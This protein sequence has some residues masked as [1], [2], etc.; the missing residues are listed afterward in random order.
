MVRK[1]Q[2]GSYKSSPSRISRCHGGGFCSIECC[3]RF[4]RPMGLADAENGYSF[5]T[6][7]GVCFTLIVFVMAVLYA[8]EKL[9]MQKLLQSYYETHI[10]DEEGSFGRKNGLNMAFALTSYT[11]DMS[12]RVTSP[13]TVTLT[14]QLRAWGTP[15]NSLITVYKN[16]DLRTHPCTEQELGFKG[17]LPEETKYSISPVVAD[18]EFDAK[19]MIGNWHCIDEEQDEEIDLFG[20]IEAGTAQ[21]LRI[22]LMKCDLTKT[23]CDKDFNYEEFFADKWIAILSNEKSFEPDGEKTINESRIS[24][25]PV[26]NAAQMS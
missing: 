20:S 17:S 13:Q 12:Q 19:R 4:S 10:T 24:W 22:N 11:G 25:I 6:G 18:Q 2:T 15:K 16:I 21:T 1:F 5:A 23:T 14:A 9:F 7:W 8:A 3:D 26:Q